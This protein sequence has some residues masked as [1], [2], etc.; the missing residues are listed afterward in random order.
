MAQNKDSKPSK[1]SLYHRAM[2]TIRERYRGE[3]N[4]VM[5]ELC[6]EHGYAYVPRLSPEERAEKK[7]QKEKEHAEEMLRRLK[8]RH[9][10]LNEE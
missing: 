4:E 2:V 10:I 7:R 9:P 1:Q 3:F 6:E 5:Q 8:E